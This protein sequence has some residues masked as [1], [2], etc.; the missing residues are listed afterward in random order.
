[1]GHGQRLDRRYNWAGS[2][3]PEPLTEEQKQKQKEK[4]KEKRRRQR[5]KKQE[6][7][8]EAAE[9]SAQAEQVAQAAQAAQ[10]EKSPAEVKAVNDKFSPAHKLSM[11][12][13]VGE[14]VQLHGR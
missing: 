3:V 8:K 13:Q 14:G 7:K 12:E 4:Q 10:A 2:A 9:A 11:A 1:M 6:K 5:E